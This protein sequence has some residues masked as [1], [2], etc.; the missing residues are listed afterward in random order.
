MNLGGPELLVVL[1]LVVGVGLAVAVMVALI[2]F[3]WKRAKS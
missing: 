1:V 3:L 2:R